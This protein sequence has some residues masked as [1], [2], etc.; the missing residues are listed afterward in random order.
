[1][2]S[3][4]VQ[5]AVRG[6]ILASMAP[7]AGLPR[8]F[9][10]YM[11][12]SHLA[13]GGMAEVFLAKQSGPSGFEKELVIK[14]ILPHLAQDQEF[15]RMFQAEAAI[16]A[17]INHPSIAHIYDYGEVDGDQY[18]AMEYVH[19]L[20][21][22]ALLRHAKAQGQT[23]IPWPIAVRIVASVAEGLDF[24]HRSRDSDGRSLGL[25]HRDVSPSNIMI[26]WNGVT[27]VLDFG[28]A[29]IAAKDAADRTDVGVVKGKVPYM[30]PE[31]LSGH[32]ID[33]RSDLFSLGVVLYETLCGIR[34]FA[35][36]NMAEIARQIVNDEPRSPEELTTSFPADLKPIL[37]RAL[38]KSVDARYQSG[39]DLKLDLEQFLAEQLVSCS[40]YDVEAYLREVVPEFDSAHRSDFKPP[41][42]LPPGPSSG[43]L[44]TAD[45]KP[46]SGT[47]ATE[48][49]SVDKE[50]KAPAPRQGLRDEPSGQLSP[51]SHE[52]LDLDAEDHRQKRRGKGGSGALTGIIVGLVLMTA[53]VFYVLHLRA[54][55]QDKRQAIKLVVPE[56]TAPVTPPP[57]TPPPVT[58]PVT[59]PVAA[60]TTPPV[61]PATKPAA[62]AD[63]KPATKPPATPEAGA[64]ATPSTA[65]KP[66]DS[67][68]PA[69]AAVK[70]PKPKKEPTEDAP[71]P[72]PRLPVPPPVDPE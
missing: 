3:S 45:A 22:S 40:N 8:A 17:R 37:W 58:P 6:A 24:A 23:G 1:M 27:K 5:G 33:A 14:R 38:S 54:V 25:V 30:S 4:A 20:T 68:K 44:S 56:V 2:T 49:A 63:V 28:V 16:A 71:R 48:M 52:G 50:K 66:V 72:L 32:E 60:K 62:T 39:R 21:L 59:P 46:A 15:V 29:K 7:S 69:D 64:V 9:G 11:L 43:S 35:A 41:A 36:E 53:A 19:G 12:L 42:P 13:T 57:V 26:C 31:Q 65:T 51:L 34:P 10:K 61:P 70:K 67:A 18:M 55:E 47:A